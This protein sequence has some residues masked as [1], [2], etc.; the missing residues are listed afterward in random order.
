MDAHPYLRRRALRMFAAEPSL[1]SR[2]LDLNVG[3]LTLSKFGLG[4]ALRLGWR[5]LTPG[6]E[7]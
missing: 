6:W 5:M 7:L 1:F 2:F 4:H 3:E